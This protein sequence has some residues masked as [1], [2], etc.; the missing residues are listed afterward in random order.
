MLV[1]PIQQSKLHSAVGSVSQFDSNED[2][3]PA[4]DISSLQ[5]NFHIILQ[6]LLPCPCSALFQ[7]GTAT[8]M[9]LHPQLIRS[10]EYRNGDLY[11]TQ[12]GGFGKIEEFSLAP[13]GKSRCHG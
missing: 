3:N 4:R 11:H 5:E 13:S 7:S 9:P 10:T 12:S 2:A 8:A 6:G 1:S